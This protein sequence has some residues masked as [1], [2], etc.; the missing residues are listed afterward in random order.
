MGENPAA[1]RAA[2]FSLSSKNLRGGRSNAPPPPQQGAGNIQHTRLRVCLATLNAHL[3][4]FQLTPS[5][6]CSCGH[7][8]ENTAHYML[9]CLQYT[10]HRLIFFNVVRSI[11]SNFDSLSSKQKLDTLLYGSNLS[12]AEGIFVTQY[13]HTYI[14]RHIGSTLNIRYHK[15]TQVR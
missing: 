1:L 6:A 9:W 3:F 7:R 4:Q 8:H 15:H 14:A 5:P 2:V 13:L 10:N 12:E 11:V